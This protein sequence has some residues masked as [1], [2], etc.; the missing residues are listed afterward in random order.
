MMIETDIAYKE[1]WSGLLYKMSFVM[2]ERIKSGYYL[3]IQKR[4]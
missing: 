1:K 4:H 2:K 3:S